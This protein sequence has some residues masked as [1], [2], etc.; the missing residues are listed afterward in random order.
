M[1]TL[2][3][4]LSK[5]LL[6]HNPFTKTALA[7]IIAVLFS[8]PA[9]AVADD[10]VIG[11]TEDAPLQTN[12]ALINFQNTAPV[13]EGPISVSYVELTRPSSD[14]SSVVI[15]NGIQDQDVR[16][17]SATVEHADILYTSSF[18][19]NVAGIQ[20]SNGIHDFYTD[21]LTANDIAIDLG[22][23]G[24]ANA[25]GILIQSSTA[26]Q[27]LEHLKVSGVSTTAGNSGGTT[28]GIR[29]EVAGFNVS[30]VEV[31]NV[32]SDN[33]SAYGIY[34][35][36][37]QV[38]VDDVVELSSISAANANAF[39]YLGA[40][41][42]WN[43]ANLNA[44]TLQVS[45]VTA[46]KSAY[47][48][49]LND[50]DETADDTHDQLDH[51][52]SIQ[53]SE[54]IMVRGVRVDENSAQGSGAYGIYHNGSTL[55][56]KLL[57]VSDV[58]GKSAA[59]GLWT[60]G[61]T[62]AD[63][64]VVSNVDSVEGEAVG[65][66]H[67]NG[68]ASYESGVNIVDQVHGATSAIGFDV[69]TSMAASMVAVNNVLTATGNAA[70]IH[71]QKTT[72][73]AT[74]DGT[75]TIV[76]TGIESKD[77]NARGVYIDGRNSILGETEFISI[78]GVKAEGGNAYGL[79]Q[80]NTTSS[81]VFTNTDGI[82]VQDVSSAT[83]IA[84]GLYL[85]NSETSALDVSV[86]DIAG[87]TAYGI[88]AAKK[89]NADGTLFIGDISGATTARG[90]YTTSDS[91]LGSLTVSAVTVTDAFGTATGIQHNNATSV[92]YS[93][94]VVVSD[95][96]GTRTAYGMRTSNAESTSLGGTLTISSVEADNAY[97]LAADGG[98]LT[99]S[100]TTTIVG[101]L[102]TDIAT[103]I[104]VES[105]SANF[106][107]V[108]IA[109]VDA[110]DV[111]ALVSAK[112]NAEVSIVSGVIRSAALNTPLTYEGHFDSD[113]EA[114]SEVNR[115]NRFALRSVEGSSI[116]MGGDNGG[117]LTIVG[118]IVAGRGTQSAADAQGGRIQI[119]AAEGSR[120][121]GDVYA[122]NGGEVTMTLVG[123]V[124]EGQIDDYHELATAATETEAFRNA[125]FIDDAGK[126]IDVTQAGAVNLTLANASTW[127]ARGQSFV[128]TVFFGQ[129]GGTID[130]TKNDNSSVSIGN[131]SGSGTFKMKLGAYSEGGT[132]AVQS[133]M[134]YIQ[135]V[136]AGSSFTINAT[137]ADGVNVSDLEGLRF[138]TVGTVADGHSTDLFKFVEIK[139]QG[140]N[141]WKLSVAKED[142][143]TGDAD[144]SR[145]NGESNGE[146][147]Y[148]PGED[149]V[150]AIYGGSTIETAALTEQ[151]KS[152]NY[153]IGAVE[154]IN[155]GGEDNPPSEPTISDAGQAI[156]ATARG[157]YYNAI[158]IDRFNQ[159]YGD[160]RYDENNKSLW[161]RVR[162]DRW[163][164]D[165]GV[166]DFKSQNTTYQMGFDYT[167]PNENGKM[168]Y[169]VAV[170]LMDGNTDYESIDGSGETKRYAV[171][172]YATYMG[173]N[174]GYLDVVGKVGRLS[175][176]YAV[177]LDSGAGISADYM[178]WMAGIS[179]EAGHQLTSNDS[180][181]FA[182]PQIQAQ[183]VF[184]SDNDYTNGQTKIE[185]DSIHSFITRAGFRAGRWLGETK[186]ANVYFK[187][188]VLHEWAGEQ[189]IHVSDQTTVRGGETFSINNHGTWFDV[190]LGFQA[191]MGKSFYAYGDAEYR[192]GNDLYQTWTFNLGG[193]YVF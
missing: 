144:N 94:D 11:G 59:A 182:E 183:Y 29:L 54:S 18:G 101:V 61:Q 67:S 160:R 33:T 165:A 27:K 175:N 121:Y 109:E 86:L 104:S 6:S 64:V 117:V 35:L 52:T 189:D 69:L 100:G 106:A 162:H 80:A 77:G 70:G 47:G 51:S 156:I 68:K 167:K 4:P 56:T 2:P 92:S 163:G 38:G 72:L 170:D 13:I 78:A 93:G 74:G 146:G 37:S 49:R 179:V 147:V 50:N 110:T 176:E 19:A 180:R 17:Q 10:Y 161:A 62:R 191:P 171:S 43:D 132:E 184:V 105:G 177:K 129:N 73:E 108:V 53:T 65:I 76:A 148:K 30:K 96:S 16:F 115:I 81:D 97:G 158:E 66:R 112:E 139:D 133:D 26:G 31:S 181:W 71:I 126:A 79:H 138:A 8:V 159:R 141:D 21:F 12:G 125:A 83:D 153:F 118:D 87:K 89:F 32:T 14:K 90:L 63:T 119:N 130:L 137:L 39:G 3:P 1:H 103:A 157:L 5:Q 45:E 85:Q 24:R 55:Q 34:N 192:F 58:S 84:Y 123:S 164:T 190:G 152:Q 75:L 168:I 149:V 98:L 193:K 116:D 169:G 22:G 107:D 60:V 7:S 131:L 102:G 25:A 57:T 166:G 95:V 186:N 120:I 111:S 128:S 23:T 36:E 142:Y 174:G 151:E 127:I 143:A 20:V 150:D 44:R 122:G 48:I 46:G 136:G 187:A 155:G 154:K 42:V 113:V 88:Y 124:L 178:N 28:S 188:D 173:D 140:F 172:A 41:T 15:F 185:Q 99:A 91:A 114:D 135:N 82:F 40:N 134:L 9:T 145:F